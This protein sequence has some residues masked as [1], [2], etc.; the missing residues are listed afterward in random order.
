MGTLLQDLRYGLR[1]LAKSPGFTAVALLT[2]A[3]GI[4][5]NT[6][7]F[8]VVN[9]VLLRPLHYQ[10]PDRLVNMNLAILP[11]GSRPVRFSLARF[12][13]LKERNHIFTDVAAVCY[14][15]QT[16]V[17]K[18][19]PN[20]IGVGRISSSF[21]NVLDIPMKLGR[22]FKPEDEAPGAP[23]VVILSYE[24]WTQHFGSD[25]QIV[26]KGIALDGL[27]YSVIGVLPYALDPPFDGTDVWITKIS[28][29][30][31]VTKEAIA[32]GSGYLNGVGRLRP[33]PSV[34]QAQVEMNALAEQFRLAHKGL[35]DSVPNTTLWLESVPDRVTSGIQ[36]PLLVLLG[37]VGF[38]L[39]ITCANIAHLM[40]VRGA[41]RYRETAIRSALGASPSRIIRQ[42]LTESLL[43]SVLGTAL[44]ALLAFW[45]LVPLLRMF[46]QDVPR[47][48]E[49]QPDFRVF[50]FALVLA[51]FTGVLFGLA[52]AL[53]SSKPNL[54]ES[55]K[56]GSRGSSGGSRRDILRG[57]LVVSQVALSLVLLVGSGLLLR[58]F[59]ALTTVRLGYQADGVLISRVALPSSKYATPLQQNMFFSQLRDRA[60]ALPGAQSVSVSRFLPFA[61]NAFSPFHIEER[62]PQEMGQRP[63]AAYNSVGQGYFE[64]LGIP[65]IKGRTFTEHDT[66]ESQFVVIISKGL[67]DKYFPGEDPVGQLI[68]VARLPKPSQVVGIVGDVKNMGLGAEPYVALYV[69]VSQRPFPN[70]LLT[71]RT[72]GDPLRLTSAVREIINAQ[73][74][75]LPKGP[76][77]TMQQM[78]RGQLS[79][80]RATMILLGSFAGVALLLASIGLYGVIAYSVSRRSR[81]IGIR[82]ALGAQPKDVMQLI[83][84]EGSRLAV[85]GV[86]AG[87]IAALFLTRL[88]RSLLFGVKATDPLTFAGVAL[89][90]LGVAL[91]ACYFP[92]RRAMRVDPVVALRNE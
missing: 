20:E 25:P 41:A 18:N 47:L 14:E 59:Q 23:P 40:L 65:L 32:N 58:S 91:A 75:A 15:N 55:L 74:K 8:S 33:G 30:T 79:Q 34:K 71:I 19:E 29:Y 5:A 13:D 88:I 7:L 67:A 61:G 76:V 54:V 78:L 9:T 4:G 60:A 11:D 21:F 85:I 12:L 3:L 26:T 22:T 72:S 36:K 64:T 66:A 50:I 45:A 84:G 82:L 57:G 68:S 90:L 2:L 52:P 92:A 80:P 1:V 35:V 44:G 69:P 51:I 73:D 46:P 49:V 87:I 37:A 24:F 56:E 31:G 48:D 28:E 16:F 42:F 6:A 53:K 17:D 77:W 39:L 89:V 38:V 70:M 81:E 43:L 63:F 27:D 62:P 10:D 86:G 83:V